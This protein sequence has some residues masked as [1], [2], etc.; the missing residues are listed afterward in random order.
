MSSLLYRICQSSKQLLVLLKP[1]QGFL[2]FIFFLVLSGVFW[3][4]T[5]LNENFDEDFIV[6]VR[7]DN[8][9]KNLVIISDQYDSIRVTV[10]DKGYN[11]LDYYR[12]R[13]T[14]E[15]SLNFHSFVRQQD[16][17]ILSQA[18][19]TKQLQVIFGNSAQIVAIKPEKLELLYCMGRPKTVP[20][21]LQSNLKLA[22]N[23]YLSETRI[24]PK[25]V[26]VYGTEETLKNVKYVKTVPLNLQEVSDTVYRELQL[27]PVHGVRIEPRKIKVT[28][29]TDIFMED[30][31]EVPVVPENVP[32][33]LRLKTFPSRIKVKYTVGISSYKKINKDLFSVQ[34]D[35]ESIANGGDKCLLKLVSAPEGVKNVA[36]EVNQVDY[37]IENDNSDNGRDR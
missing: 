16:K 26:T 17:V 14:I 37:L 23:Y 34:A 20:V 1:R 28:L 7:I 21:V 13:Q 31:V 11:L 33:G 36:L 35:Y 29:C 8:L 10:H 27:Q 15:L 4:F 25:T 18:E 5:T 9:P 19:L 30:V 24:E 3:L 12:R 6:P 2:T 32:Q 22:D